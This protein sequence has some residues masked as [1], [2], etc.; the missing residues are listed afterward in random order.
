MRKSLAIVTIVTIN[1][2]I[3][4]CSNNRKHDKLTFSKSVEMKANL[5][6]EESPLM[7]YPLDMFVT[8][9]IIYVLNLMNQQWLHCY[10]K[11]TGEY[12]SGNI[13]QGRGP[14]EIVS[15]VQM[16]YD[17]ELKE[18]NLFDN[19]TE[20]LL[21]F[22]VPDSS[23]KLLFKKEISFAEVPQTVFIKVW[24]LS[25]NTIIANVQCGSLDDSLTRFQI[26]T[27]EGELLDTCSDI[28]PL[29]G[30][31]R[32][33]LQQTSITMSPDC[34]QLASVTLFGEILELYALSDDAISDR[35]EKIFA[36]PCVEFR[37]GVL[38]ET[39]DTVMGFPFVCSDKE[40]IYASMI[41]GTDANKFDKIAIF[42][43]KGNALMK[44][45]T[46][47]N[48]LRLS[49]FDNSLYAIVANSSN[50]LFFARYDLTL[51]SL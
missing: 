34:R 48:V 23:P 19:A 15:C 10:D 21:V 13:S 14:G 36:Y 5:I 44:V 33:T 32:F 40:F 28:P 39:T 35:H 24:P 45:I 41:D 26:F 30:D 2:V 12:L 38:W 31:D 46:D 9:S 43:W 50:D 20:K 22:S 42:D 17:Q 47:Y 16:W 37:D 29:V 6:S 11:V 8:D 27:F 1:L 4:S 3:S 51:L 7:S 25:D 49:A 18:I